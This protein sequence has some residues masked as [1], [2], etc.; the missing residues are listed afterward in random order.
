MLP[1]VT[2]PL[3]DLRSKPLISHK[4]NVSSSR[5]HGTVEAVHFHHRGLGIDRLVAASSGSSFV[6]VLMSET[7]IFDIGIAP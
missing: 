1:N 7:I 3:A 2:M 4:P 6:I 5:K